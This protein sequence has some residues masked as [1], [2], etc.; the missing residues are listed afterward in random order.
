MLKMCSSRSMGLKLTS[1]DQAWKRSKKKKK[2]KGRT[3]N[4][5][6]IWLLTNRI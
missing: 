3:S 1:I 5:S 6:S 4:E 2:F